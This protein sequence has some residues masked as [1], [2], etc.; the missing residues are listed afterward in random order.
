MVLQMMHF[1]S[2]KEQISHAV[3]KY[4]DM[5]CLDHMEHSNWPSAK[6]VL[7]EAVVPD[8]S[9]VGGIC[10]LLYMFM[11]ALSPQSTR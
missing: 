4:F 11:A 6:Y 9:F 3:T 5:Y 8:V 7:A 2:F 10:Q 1:R